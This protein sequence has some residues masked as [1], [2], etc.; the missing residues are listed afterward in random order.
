MLGIKSDNVSKADTI[1]D[2]EECTVL[3]EGRHHL[4]KHI[5]RAILPDGM[6]L[7]HACPQQSALK[8][9]LRSPSGAIELART[10]QVKET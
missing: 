10:L 5:T 7:V 4:N 8:S 6:T 2:F 1:P 9:L 3:R